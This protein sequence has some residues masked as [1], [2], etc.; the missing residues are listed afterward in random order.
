MLRVWDVMAFLRTKYGK[1]YAA[2]TRETIRRQTLHQ[3]EQAAD[4]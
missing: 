1:D 2:N 4:R 3:F